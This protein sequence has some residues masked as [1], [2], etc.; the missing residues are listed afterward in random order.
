MCYLLFTQG[1][2]AQARFARGGSLL[3]T[4]NLPAGPK[5]RQWSWLLWPLANCLL[6]VSLLVI[7]SNTWLETSQQLAEPPQLHLQ[8]E[9]SSSATWEDPDYAVAD[10]ADNL[11]TAERQQ[12][13]GYAVMRAHSVVFTGITRDNAAHMNETLNTIDRIGQLFASYSVIVYENDSEDNTPGIIEAWKLANTDAAHIEFISEQL[14][15]PPAI[16]TGPDSVERMQRLADSRNKVLDKLRGAEY[17]RYS[18]AIDLDLDSYKIELDGIAHSFGV[19]EQWDTVAANGQCHR[20]DQGFYY[21]TMAFRSADY[22]DTWHDKEQIAGAQRSYPSDGP[23]VPV[24]SAFG[25]LAVYKR[26]CLI[27]CKYS[28]LDNEHV[29]LHRCLQQTNGCRRLYSN[30][31]M[32]LDYDLPC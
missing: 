21:D 7:H 14:N 27:A 9:H 26:K 10:V 25:G 24:N 3:R 17:E 12:Q 20:G 19:F 1:T 5:L 22:P 13:R 8:V 15:V 4:R 6:F 29:M 2:L 18:Y 28:G 11:T 16:A 23:L 31:G 30:P 32:K